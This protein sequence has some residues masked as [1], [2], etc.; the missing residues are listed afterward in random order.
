[1]DQRADKVYRSPMDSGKN[2]CVGYLARLPRP[3]QHG[4]FLYACG[5]HAMGLQGVIHFVENNLA[6]L[7][8]EVR[9]RRFS[10]AIE[11]DFAPE[12]HQVTATRGLTPL[13]R[14]DEA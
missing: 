3:D 6:K 5:I 14:H 13:Y 10:M 8:E 7:Y 12:G 11:C 2:S 9:T 1:M 4:T